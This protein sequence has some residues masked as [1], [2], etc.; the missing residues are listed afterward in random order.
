MRC[1]LAQAGYTTTVVRKPEG[2][3]LNSFELQFILADRKA[4]VGITDYDSTKKKRV[5]GN[6]HG[7]VRASGKT[8]NEAAAVVRERLS[9]TSRTE[10]KR[11]KLV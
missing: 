7:Y 4:I 3:H 6:V 5:T 10:G 1:L 9:S 8:L 11:R 2:S